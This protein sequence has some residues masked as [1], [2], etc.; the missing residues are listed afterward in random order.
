MK[1][2]ATAWLALLV[3]A[4]ALGLSLARMRSPEP[5]PARALTPEAG[6]EGGLAA[7]VARL[8]RGLARLSD[9]PPLL[10]SAP[11]AA[12]E[13][14]PSGA[15]EDGDLAE[16]FER[17]QREFERFV[18][19]REAQ[20]PAHPSPTP[21]EL[22]RRRAA[23]IDERQGVARDLAAAEAD[24]LKALRGLRGERLPDGTDARLG[25]L[26]D[27]IRLAEA[28]Q[29]PLTRADVWRQ[30]SGVR[31]PTLIGPLLN[32]LRHDSAAKVRE[33]AA[34]TLANF[35]SEA[36]VEPAL[37]TAAA[38]DADPGVQRQ[39]RASLGGPR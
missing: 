30:L 7:R 32:A 36:G 39:A 25:V 18:A 8:E 3:A 5:S 27:M 28:S 24:R 38:H 12:R 17:L 33:E 21:D 22:A 15:S 26:L 29:D 35:L 14:V 1:P 23:E 37:Q 31:D 16:R 19:E 9:E 20:T 10:R 11:H 2:A 13:A 6:D 34:E 4:A